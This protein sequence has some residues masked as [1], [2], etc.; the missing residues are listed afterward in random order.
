MHTQLE[1]LPSKNRARLKH[2][3]FFC[4]KFLE[5]IQQ[6]IT[7]DPSDTQPAELQ[8]VPL[9]NSLVHSP[10]SQAHPSFSLLHTE[11]F[12]IQHW[13]A[14]M[15]PGTRQVMVCL[16]SSGPFPAFQWAWGL[17][18]LWLAYLQQEDCQDDQGE[19]VKDFSRIDTRR[20]CG[21]KVL[22]QTYRQLTWNRSIHTCF[23]SF[24]SKL[25]WST[26]ILSLSESARTEIFL[27]IALRDTKIF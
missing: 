15:D 5:E 24:V 10:H 23:E 27:P 8:L 6:L 16:W 3:F 7:I 11:K 21:C 9:G 12:S 2:N 13:K 4:I 25:T 14:G 20:L 1:Y 26:N 19:D 18:Y 22:K 17:G